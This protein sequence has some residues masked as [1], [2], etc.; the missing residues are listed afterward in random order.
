MP[1]NGK[2]SGIR[3]AEDEE[4]MALFSKSGS[5]SMPKQAVM[6]GPVFIKPFDDKSAELRALS[7]KLEA[8]PPAAKHIFREALTSLREKVELHTS[9]FKALS[10]SGI[11]FLALHDLNVACKSAA[12]DVDFA[13]LTPTYMVVILCRNH[14][15]RIDANDQWDE[16]PMGS[17][18]DGGDAEHAAYVVSEMLRE[19][20]I[21]P[22]KVLRN[23][24]PVTVITKEA[25][26]MNG[27]G[28]FRAVPEKQGLIYPEIRKCQMLSPEEL[29]KFLNA[30]NQHTSDSESIPVKKLYAACE[31]LEA[32]HKEVSGSPLTYRTATTKEG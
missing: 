6:Q 12:T 2:L 20:R 31:K 5:G 32:Y 1:D 11:S 28:D 21:L 3:K 17:D 24:W 13:V 19:G 30:L 15:K 22:G 25:A 26:Q 10:E 4:I 18:Q 8:A 27:I 7:L 29:I 23:I 9:V 16:L 14:S